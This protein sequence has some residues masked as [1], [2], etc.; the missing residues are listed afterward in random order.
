MV[1]TA[2]VTIPA[3]NKQI[4]VPTGLFI[5][6][7][8][9]PSVDSKETIPCYNPATE[10]LICEVV[11]ASPKDIDK[12]VEAARRAFNTTWGKN[13]NGFE[14]ARLINKLAD[15]I[16]RDA[17]ELAELETLNNGKPVRVAR[18]FDIGDTVQCLRY[19]AGWSDKVP[20]S[21][22]FLG[23]ASIHSAIIIKITGQSIEVDNQ[24]KFAFTRH[25]PIGV[26][27]QII[28]WNYPINMWAW[29]VAPALARLYLYSLP[30]PVITIH[31]HTI[32][33]V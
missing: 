16:E 26:C 13:V 20:V 5:D 7:E 6:N 17:Q 23:S 31:W 21:P 24:T 30:T 18:D 32:E 22:F 4:S 2:T 9:V 15:L 27:G 11:A 1:Q 28:P 25:E 3:L 29:K 33:I 10:E 8:F 14:R 12:A 19:Y